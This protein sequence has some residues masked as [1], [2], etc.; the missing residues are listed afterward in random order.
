MFVLPMVVIWWRRIRTRRPG[1]HIA[2]SAFG[3]CSTLLFNI[4]LI[5]LPVA[6]ASAPIFTAPLIVAALSVV[7][8]GEPVSAR[9]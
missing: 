8:L 9:R 5:W 3:I 2:R 6:D 7:V 1:L 4:A